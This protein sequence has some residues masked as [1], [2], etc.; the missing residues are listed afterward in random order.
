[1]TL[2]RQ[3]LGFGK[4]I[5]TLSFFKFITIFVEVILMF[6]SFTK[7]LKYIVRKSKIRVP[8]SQ[9]ATPI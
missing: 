8:Y 1:M 4:S 3:P 6:H 2:Q 7:L 5:R 9:S